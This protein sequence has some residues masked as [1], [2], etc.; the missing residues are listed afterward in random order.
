[1]SDDGDCA[2]TIIQD[3]LG[4]ESDGV[5]KYSG[6]RILAHRERARWHA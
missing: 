3:A 1:M 2:A 4:I 6:F 5:V